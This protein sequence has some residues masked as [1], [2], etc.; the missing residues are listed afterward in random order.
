[1]HLR[2]NNV[3]NTVGDENVASDNAG[4]VDEDAS[5]VDGDGQVGAVSSTEN[6]SVGKTRAVADSAVDYV[7]GQDVG[8]VGGGKVSKTTTDGLESGVRGRED[9]DIRGVVDNIDKASGVERPAKG[10]QVGSGKSVGSILW[11]SKEVVNDM[12]DTTGEVNVGLGNSRVG[13]KSTEEGDIAVT[14]NSLNPL[15]SGHLN[16][17]S[18]FVQYIAGNIEYARL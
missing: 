16:S 4:V 7:V 18:V 11:Q 13:Q 6:G 5:L 10:D 9:G 12:N 8:D 1:M 2:V 3:R 17:K 15:A 14:E